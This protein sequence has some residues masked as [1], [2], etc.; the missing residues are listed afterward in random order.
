MHHWPET[1]NTVF[2]GLFLRLQVQI[3]V[4]IVTSLIS[5]LNPSFSPFLVFFFFSLWKWPWRYPCCA[6]PNTE[7]SVSP[8]PHLSL[9][10]CSVF[11]SG[12]SQ[13]AQ[14]RPGA[15]LTL[16]A[17]WLRKREK[18]LWTWFIIHEPHDTSFICNFFSMESTADKPHTVFFI[19]Y[20][21]ITLTLGM[22]VIRY[23]SQT[24]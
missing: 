10:L 1:L 4:L 17:Y 9:S 2:F 16:Q 6:C 3:S 23:T 18:I 19:I 13:P 14:G 15:V 24:N 21:F 22:S 5:S 12:L 11:I 7:L 20:F 8:P